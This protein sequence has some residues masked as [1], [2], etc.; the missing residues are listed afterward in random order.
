MVPVTQN[1]IGAATGRRPL[2]LD[3]RIACQ[4]GTTRCLEEL[5]V[6]RPLAI[7]IAAVF[8]SRPPSEGPVRERLMA[9]GGGVSETCLRPGAARASQRVGSAVMRARAQ[10]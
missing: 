4:A 3:R 7:A 10:A 8:R 5:G 2:E 9:R 6:R 1:D